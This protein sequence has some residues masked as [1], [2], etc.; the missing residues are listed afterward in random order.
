MLADHQSNPLQCK[1]NQEKGNDVKRDLLAE[2]AAARRHG[3]A[4][5]IAT[6][7]GLG[8]GSSTPGLVS[9]DDI[10]A[11]KA[12]VIPPPPSICQ[13]ILSS[14]GFSALNEEHPSKKRRYSE[15]E[16]EDVC[17]KDENSHMKAE[18]NRMETQNHTMEDVKS[19]N[20]KGGPV[21]IEEEHDLLF[22]KANPVQKQD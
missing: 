22:V 18:S 20:A 10:S 14:E 3:Q 6:L 19:T 16:G 2:A 7:A 12:L 8:S 1:K 4:S 15:M 17:I 21:T 5:S 11:R 9:E 13:D